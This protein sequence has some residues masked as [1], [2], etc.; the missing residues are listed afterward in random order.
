VPFNP[1]D[2]DKFA[3]YYSGNNG[4]FA[5]VYRTGDRY[6]L[7]L[8]GQQ[9]GLLL[10]FPRISKAEFDAGG[11]QLA[12]RVKDNTPSPGTQDMV[13]SYIKALEQGRQQNYDT[14][15]PELAAAAR[16]QSS[17]ASAAIRQ[18]G[19]FKSLEFARVL[20]DG[21][22]MYIATFTH[23]QLMWVIMPLTKDGKV[24]GMVFRPFPP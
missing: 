2:F 7:Q 22:N 1:A 18:E 19:A 10:S 23:G 12:K 11:A 3:G 17:Q 24:P 16:Q 14:M 9:S 6:F 13:L 8:T 15:T 4:G 21:A 20:P 5:H